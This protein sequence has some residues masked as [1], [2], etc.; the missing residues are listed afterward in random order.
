M[1]VSRGNEAQNATGEMNMEM[2]DKLMRENAELRAEVER[3]RAAIG[4]AKRVEATL[5]RDLRHTRANV[6]IVVEQVDALEL[7]RR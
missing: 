5:R 4:V 3:L 2:T 1:S 6:A 7:E